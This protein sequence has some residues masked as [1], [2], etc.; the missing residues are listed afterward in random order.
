MFIIWLEDELACFQ[1]LVCHLF[2]QLASSPKCTIS[3]TAAIVI[4]AGL[5]KSHVLGFTG[6][7]MS[8]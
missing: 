5:E 7:A 8:Q 4:V 2:L 6:P 3:A 1:A